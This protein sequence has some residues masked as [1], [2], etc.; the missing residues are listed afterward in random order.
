MKTILIT[1]GSGMIGRGLSEL[2]IEKGY[3]VIWLSRERYKSAEIPR[4]RWDYRRNEIDIEALEKADIV[5]HLAGSN[6]GEGTWVRHKKQAIVESRVLTAKLLLETYQSIN[7]KPE[8]F[9]SASAVGYY[10]MHTDEKIYT[11]EDQPAVIDF[12]SRTCKK[13]ENAAFNFN[14]ELSVRTV[15]IRTSFVV[16]KQSEAFKKL[17]FPIRY[18]LGAPLGKGDQY[19]SWIHLDDI[20]GIYIKAI[21]DST[22]SGIYNAASPDHVTNSEF[23]QQA[24]K[25]LNRP[26]FIPKIPSFFLRLIMGESSGMI[27]EGSRISSKKTTDSGYKFKYPKVAQAIKDSL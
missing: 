18:G 26:F 16:A 11:E 12:L 21:E 14:D 5:V 22:M 13:W 3:K 2:L 8:T 19:M 4:Y 27:L 15:V 17:A 6:L 24:A 25:I 10:G 20:C 7:K 1:G 23:M 9:I